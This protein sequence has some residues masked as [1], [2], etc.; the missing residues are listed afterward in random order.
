MCLH[1]LPAL[2]EGTDARERGFANNVAIYSP[3]FGF[4]R[5]AASFICT[6]RPPSS[7][8]NPSCSVARSAQ[9]DSI[10]E[11]D[12]RYLESLA[13]NDLPVI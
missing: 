12:R 11:M 2:K 6:A 5:C 10:R 13:K 3:R 1:T 8:I 9:I 7:F 4:A